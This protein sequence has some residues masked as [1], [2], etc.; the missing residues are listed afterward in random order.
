MRERRLRAI[1]KSAENLD[2]LSNGCNCIIK[3]TGREVTCN[4]RRSYDGVDVK[5]I[6]TLMYIDLIE[7]TFQRPGA[8]VFNGQSFIDALRNTRR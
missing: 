4:P 2:T 5:G 3:K 6:G 8:L 1:F 7:V